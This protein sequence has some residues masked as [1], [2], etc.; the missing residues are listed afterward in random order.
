[1]QNGTVATVKNNI[2]FPQK[3]KIEPPYDPAIPFLDTY[4]E[5]LKSGSFKRYWHSCV[6]CGTICNST[7]VETT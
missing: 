6:Y 5:E 7:D 4:W 1:M 3:I 2:E